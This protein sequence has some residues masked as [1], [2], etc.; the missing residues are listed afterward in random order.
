MLPNTEYTDE[1]KGTKKISRRM[2]FFDGEAEE[3]EFQGS[4]KF[5][6]ETY[7]P[8]IDSLKSNLE[9]R[10]TAYEKINDNFGFLVNI[11]K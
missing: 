5:K 8:C 11:Q 1:S 4:L 9:K 10:S 6:V 2:A 3:M 7:L